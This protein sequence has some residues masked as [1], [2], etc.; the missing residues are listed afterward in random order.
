MTATNFNGVYVFGKRKPDVEKK[1][2][3]CK[4]SMAEALKIVAKY[5]KK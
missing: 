1:P 4:L 5:Q 2:E 3:K